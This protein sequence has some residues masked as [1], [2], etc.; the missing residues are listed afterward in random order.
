MPSRRCLALRH[1]RL[2]VVLAAF[3]VVVLVAAAAAAVS[4]LAVPLR[5]RV[6]V[7]VEFKGVRWS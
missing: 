3:V 6:V 7:G 2:P 5:L 4:F 1:D